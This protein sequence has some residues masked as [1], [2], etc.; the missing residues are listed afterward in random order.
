MAESRAARWA[1]SPVVG[2]ATKVRHESVDE[3]TCAP[4]TGCAP[5][6]LRIAEPD[7]AVA[8]LRATARASALFFGLMFGPRGGQSRPSHLALDRRARGRNRGLMPR[9]GVLSSDYWS[10][11][12]RVSLLSSCYRL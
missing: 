6:Q 3:I 10:D 8:S 2:I 7:I 11:G 5:V 1:S 9:A 12:G 4:S